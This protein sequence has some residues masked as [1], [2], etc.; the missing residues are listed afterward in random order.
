MLEI[1]IQE[2][3]LLNKL[4]LV[5]FYGYCFL[6][7]LINSTYADIPLF[8]RIINIFRILSFLFL[9]AD[10]IINR[11][12]I[13]TKIS[14][15]SLLCLLVG[16]MNFVAS[17]NY[18]LLLLALFLCWSKYYPLKELMKKAKNIYFIAII[19]IVISSLLGIIPMYTNQRYNSV[20]IR[21]ALGFIAP[22]LLPAYFM[23]ALLMDCYVHDFCFGKVKIM[24]YSL[25]LFIIYVIT[26]T[27]FDCALC[28]FILLLTIVFRVLKKPGFSIKNLLSGQNSSHFS[29]KI[30]SLLPVLCFAIGILLVVGYQQGISLFQTIADHLSGRIQYTIH[31]MENHSFTLLGESITWSEEGIILDSSYFKCLFE[32]GIVGFLF[33]MV[34]YFITLE[35]ALENKDKYLFLI[36]TII[37]FESIFEPFLYDYNYNLFT[38][39][40]VN[41]S[42]AYSLS[43]TDEKR[44]CY[45]VFAFR[46]N[47]GDVYFCQESF[48]RTSIL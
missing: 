7:V 12:L 38:L 29:Y 32:Q 23:F 5:A 22:T 11:I 33:V 44:E 3:T 1:T 26:D 9:I 37:L 28:L 25:F 2:K 41:I 35:K 15:M 27:R 30:I 39:F 16:G 14:K 47:G 31:A 42:Y 17:H 45:D 19:F 21:Y 36:L 48:E 34:Y 13:P 8:R 40:F 18:K 6:G 4:S 10:T 24:A 46:L 43:A 20:S